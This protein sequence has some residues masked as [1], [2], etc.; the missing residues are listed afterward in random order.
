MT[1]EIAWGNPL[2]HLAPPGLILSKHSTKYFRPEGDKKTKKSW[3]DAYFVP[4]CKQ[5]WE[6]RYELAE[7]GRD[8]T[9][10]RSKPLA[11][12]LRNWLVLLYICIYIY[13]YI[14]ICTSLW[15]KHARFVHEAD[16]TPWHFRVRAADRTPWQLM[17]AF[18]CMYVFMSVCI[19]VRMSVSMPLMYACMDVCM[20]GWL[21]VCMYVPRKFEH[22]RVVAH[23]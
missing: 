13:I 18:V 9:F 10:L 21:Y 12:Y 17:C 19:Y 5:W 22:I 6:R 16:R 23:S 3:R 1:S 14:Y 11:F 20:D 15:H 7:V 4:K 8:R 2:D